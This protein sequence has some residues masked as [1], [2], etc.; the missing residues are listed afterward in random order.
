MKWDLC[1]PTLF[2][3]IGT[4]LVVTEITSGICFPSLLVEPMQTGGEQR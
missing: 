3:D 1:W 4:V 2:P